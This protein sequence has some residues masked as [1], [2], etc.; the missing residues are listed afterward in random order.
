ML[1]KDKRSIDADIIRPERVRVLI[2][3]ENASIDLSGE[4]GLAVHWFLGLLKE[5]VD[6]HLLVHDRRKSELDK[7]LSSFTPRIHYVPDLLIQKVCW[8][9]GKTL[10][11]HVRSFTTE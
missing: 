9:L 3:A 5:E 7:S 11:S 4:A 6:V 2:V 10:P 8:K 1:P